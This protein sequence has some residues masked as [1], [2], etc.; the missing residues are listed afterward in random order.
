MVLLKLNSIENLLRRNG[1]G[2]TVGVKKIIELFQGTNF[3]S[4]AS[5]K[6][7][8]SWV[9]LVM[10]GRWI[11]SDCYKSHCH[12]YSSMGKLHALRAKK[13]MHLRTMI[14]ARFC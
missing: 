14:G 4:R 13:V 12:G 11:D 3:S 9:R 10:H 8:E 7:T 5:E 6:I 1:K 2:K